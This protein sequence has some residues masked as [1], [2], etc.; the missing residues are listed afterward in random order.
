MALQYNNYYSNAIVGQPMAGGDI[1]IYEV[2]TTPKFAVGFGFVRADG[3]KYRYCQFS[4]VTTP[5]T[6][7]MTAS[8]VAQVT[9]VNGVIAP[10]SAV[11]VTGENIAPGSIGSRYFEVTLS[12]VSANQLSGNTLCIYSGTGAGLTYRVRGNTKT[13]GVASGNVRIQLYEPLVL[14]VDAS[15]DIVLMQSPY[16]NVVAAYADAASIN[17]IAGV[18]CGSVNAANSFGWVCEEG[19]VGVK[20]SAAITVGIGVAV[21]ATA[22][23]IDNWVPTA[24]TCVTSTGVV[25]NVAT[26]PMI[27]RVLFNGGAGEIGLIRLRAV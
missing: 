13:G 19:E 17:P 9:T 26:Q 3:N 5:A 27:G 23:T 15:S 16:N 20:Q 21:G 22:G 12:G 6:L 25:T 7:V 10:A 11:A 1:D 2:N 4:A 14:A 8:N 18:A 24:G